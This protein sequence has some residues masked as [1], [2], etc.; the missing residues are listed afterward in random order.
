MACFQSLIPYPVF[1]EVRL[2]SS[3]SR[4]TLFLDLLDQ[5]GHGG[6]GWVELTTFLQEWKPF[7]DHYIVL[8]G[9][10]VECQKFGRALFA[11]LFPQGSELLAAWRAIEAARGR[12]HPVHMTISFGP[13]TEA[14]AGLPLELLHDES[15]F[16]FARPNH[17]LD[18]AFT[19]LEPASTDWRLSSSSQVLFVWACPTGVQPFDPQPHS[20][21][22]QRIF[23]RNR[24]EL[25]P[26]ASLFDVDTSLRKRKFDLLHLLAH[27][28]HPEDGTGVVVFNNGQGHVEYVPAQ[29]LAQTLHGHGIQLAFLCSCQSAMAR[30][31]LL[32]GTA[33]QLLASPVGEGIGAVVATQ[34]NLPVA[35]SALLAETFYRLLENGDRPGP[36]LARARHNAFSGVLPSAWSVPILLTRPPRRGEST[37]RSHSRSRVPPLPEAFLPRPEHSDQI[38]ELLQK[39][40]VVAVVGLPGIGKTELCKVAAKHV[41]ENG[42]GHRVLY[43]TIETAL[44]SDLLRARVAAALGE[45]QPP[46]SDWQLAGWL[47]EQPTLLVLD[48]LEAAMGDQA[49]QQAMARQ[50]EAL[51]QAAPSLRLLLSTRWA[52][53]MQNPREKHYPIPPMSPGQTEAMLR[54][55]LEQQGGFDPKW[56]Q[57][58]A[59]KQLLAFLDGHP[60]SVWLVARHF[61]EPGSVSL[62]TI[63]SRLQ[64]YKD[65][66]IID[67]ALWGRVDLPDL[68]PDQRRQ[69]TSLVASMNFSFQVLRQRHPEAVQAFLQLS[70]FPAGLPESVA[71]T[72]TGGRERLV[73]ESLYRY[74]LL[75]WRNERVFYPVPLR[76]YAERLAR[77]DE[78][79]T[80]S[81]SALLGRAIAAYAQHMRKVST[82]NISTRSPWRSW[83]SGWRTNQPCCG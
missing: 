2:P 47:E 42:S 8:N 48:N 60:R 10:Y 4:Q 37:R 26:N 16:V 13:L 17:A 41:E 21:M 71:W 49:N 74:H 1:L 76:W 50:L 52:A 81:R 23:G 83:N 46:E 40:R 33:Q 72:V 36:A 65:Q 58:S 63:V 57:D 11:L 19:Q 28:S 24:V 67:P 25:C 78:A 77:D 12:D 82:L 79:L 38:L 61:E 56:L 39:N 15:G 75:E 18:R 55:E 69:M 22:L 73:L 30:Q 5:H 51:A 68:D 64:T 35:N 29:R 70:I 53:G 7:L 32:A 80:T 66:A 3:L 44:A 20:D 9:G 6:S 45:S 59:W 34:A 31:F 54:G 62:A 14:L 43:L 27:G